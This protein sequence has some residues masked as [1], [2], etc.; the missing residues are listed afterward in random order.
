MRCRFSWC[1]NCFLV[2]NGGA[3]EAGHAGAVYCCQPSQDHVSHVTRRTSKLLQAPHTH[4]FCILCIVLLTLCKI[5][6]RFSAP[7]LVRLHLLDGGRVK[8][9]AVVENVCS[10]FDFYCLRGQARA[11]VPTDGCCLE[12]AQTHNGEHSCKGGYRREIAAA[13]ACIQ[14]PGVY[15][16]K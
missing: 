13:K 9:F 16:F 7:V 12:N 5:L 14:R 2:L 1:Y 8:V 3:G 6:L 4:I 15:G 10:C 11:H